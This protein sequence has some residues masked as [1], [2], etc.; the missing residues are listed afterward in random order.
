[1]NKKGEIESPL[2]TIFTGT[3][4]SEKIIDRVFSSIKNQTLRNFEWIVIDDCSKDNTLDKVE[5]FVQELSDIY[6]RLIKHEVNTGVGASRKEALSHAKGKYFV[7]WDHD[8][9]QSE[10]QLEIFQQLWSKHD[11]ENVST[12]FAKI[13]D[14]NG[15]L[16]GKKY[17][18][19]PYISDYINA[20]NTYLV[21]N[22]ES[23][24]V[25]EHHV[26]AKTEKYRMVLNYFE[27]NTHLLRDHKPNGG[28]IW[29][30]L[31]FL[32]YNTL[33]TNQIVRT[34][35]I[36]EGG[37]K[38]MSNEPRKKGAERI[39][40]YKLLWVNHWQNKLKNKSLKWTLRNYLAVA[41]YGF[42]AKKNY[43]EIMKD[44]KQTNSKIG[45][46][47]LALPGFILSKRYQ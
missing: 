35:Y 32:G 5:D 2:F 30:T 27:E 4:N 23:G 21:G 42:L 20:H 10:H 18:K 43:F 28:D 3:Y 14:Q 22:K 26:C 8:D 47:I 7:T 39:Y 38:T 12:I 6:V 15:K 17:P 19:E 45:F 13:K 24:N 44:L 40:L 46:F 16:L 37:R 36:N 41:M 34:Y 29:G 25:I 11:A 31:A 33:Y 9:I 1:M